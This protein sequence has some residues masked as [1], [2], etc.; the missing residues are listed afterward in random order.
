MSTNEEN[1]TPAAPIEDTALTGAS[2]GVNHCG[3]W[4]EAAVELPAP[5]EDFGFGGLPPET[6]L[7][8]DSTLGT[9]TGGVR[10]D[11][12]TVAEEDD[13]RRPEIVP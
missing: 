3:I 7:L 4:T 13:I 2:G 12:Y 11:I 1:K 5:T 6:E 8:K 10:H 9:V